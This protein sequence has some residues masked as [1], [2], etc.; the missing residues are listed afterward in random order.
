MS[1]VS[2][3]MN[4]KHDAVKEIEVNRVFQLDHPVNTVETE[5]EVQT[6]E[7]RGCSFGECESITT[8]KLHARLNGFLQS[9]TLDLEL[10]GARDS[11]LGLWSAL[12]KNTES[13]DDQHLHLLHLD[14]ACVIAK[15][16]MENDLEKSVHEEENRMSGTSDESGHAEELDAVVESLIQEE[17]LR[18]EVSHFTGRIHLYVCVPGKDLRPRSLSVNFRPEELNSIIFSCGE[19]KN[20]AA[21]Q[22]LKKNPSYSNILQKFIKEWS[23]LRPIEHHKLLGKPLQ[24]PLSLELCYLNETVNHGSNGLLKGGSKRRVTPLSEISSSLPQNAVWKNVVLYSGSSKKKD[25]TQAW[26]VCGKPLCKLCHATCNGKLSTTPEFFEDLFCNMNCY[27][28]YRVRTSQKALREAL[29]QIEHGVCVKCN[30]DC[31]K[32]VK[33]ISPLSVERRR[34]HIEEEAPGLAKKKKLLEKLVNEPIEGNAWHADHIVPVFRGGGECKVE[35]MRTL[36]VVC[37]AEVTKAQRSELHLAR[38]KA[39]EQLKIAMKRLETLETAKHTECDLTVVGP[40]V[41]TGADEDDLIV[42]VPGSAYSE[43]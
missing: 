33:S 31:H 8:G 39:K 42:K 23:N 27:Q 32:L 12:N 4:G 14:K 19:V 18:F 15:D 13:N 6:V 35:N 21:T 29:F 37:H 10:N 40:D 16:G 30:L 20:E 25:Y 41:V 28:E 3:M 1:R 5:Q 38:K 22:L 9:Q 11:D 7:M 34:K 17:S 24:L 36:C 2:S 43:S 26:T